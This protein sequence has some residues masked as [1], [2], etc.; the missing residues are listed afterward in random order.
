MIGNPMNP[1][2]PHETP[3]SKPPE[4]SLE[5]PSKVVNPFVMA[6]THSVS[7]L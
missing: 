3:N 7:L 2:T 4:S 5:V 1:Q 6:I